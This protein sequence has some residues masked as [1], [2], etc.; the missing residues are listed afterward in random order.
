M[1]VSTRYLLTWKLPEGVDYVEEELHCH[2]SLP[3]M[4]FC[5]DCGKPTGVNGFM[6]KIA[7]WIRASEERSFCLFVDGSPIEPGKWYE[8]ESDM[9]ELS[10]HHPEVLFTLDMVIET[11]EHH[12]KY[13]MG[14][15]MQHAP[16]KITFDD[17]NRSK[18]KSI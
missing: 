4:K 17:F 16:G 12:R 9:A 8:H 6:T 13:F 11:T 10:R 7:D 2:G 5:P 18:L 15:L 14:G 1:G 3:G